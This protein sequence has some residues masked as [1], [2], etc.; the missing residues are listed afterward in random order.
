MKITDLSIDHRTTVFALVVILVILGAYTYRSLPREAFPEVEIPVVMV[1]TNFAGVS[2]KDMEGNV[3][4]PLEN[5]LKGLDD[6]EEMKS[7]SAEGV[8]TISIEFTPDVD[9][10][11]ALQKVR[12][13]VDEALPEMPEDIDDP[14][15]Q[16]ISVSDF[17]VVYV[18]V[19]GELPL[20][21][22]KAVA[23]DLEDRIEVIAGVLDADVIGG[24][25]REIR[26]ELDFD[27][28]S[29]YDIPVAD[30]LSV[31]RRENENITGGSIEMDDAKFSVRVPGEF[32]SP[33]Q[34]RNIVLTMRDGKPIYVTDVARVVDTYKDQTSRSRLN[35]RECVSIAV[36]KRSGENII[37]V[38]EAVKE[39]LDEA[40]PTLPKGVILSVSNDISK[41]VCILV[42]DL[43]NNI[44]SGFI[45]VVGVVLLFMGFRNSLFVALAVPMSM[46]ITMIVLTMLGMT[47][48]MM[49]LFSLI[50]TLGMLVD[51]AIVIVENTFRHRQ[52]GLAAADAAKTATDEVAWPVITSTLTTVCAFF[53]MIFWPGVMGQ[54]MSYLPMTVILALT[55]SLGVA[56]VIN[57]TFCARFMKVRAAQKE[58]P[59]QAVRRGYE[60]LLHAALDHRAFVC[61]LAVAGLVGTFMAYA[62]LGKGVV[63]FP[64]IDP[65][66]AYVD[67]EAPEGT[68]LDATDAI[69]R[70]VE[71][72]AADI[73]PLG[74]VKETI[75]NIGKTGGSPLRGATADAANIARIN[76]DFIDR[77]FRRES[78]WNVVKRLRKAVE[79]IA[80]AEIRVDRPEEGPPTGAPVSVEISGEDFDVLKQTAEKVKQLIKD[81]PGLVDLK[82]DFVEERPELAFRVD[83]QRAALLG[84]STVHVATVLKLAISGMKVG[85]YRELNEDYDITLRL[86]E[87]ERRTLDDIMRLTIPDLQGRQV[88]LS[89]VARMEYAPGLGAINRKD[90][91][92]VITV[93]AEKAVGY[94]SAQLLAKV[95]EKLKELAGGSS[96]YR[97][98]YTG[99]N[100]ESEKAS[101]FLGK[102]FAVAVFLILLVL[103]TQF[104]SV[105][106]P[107]IILISVI[108][109]LMGVL[110]GLIVTRTP[111]SII[112][113]GIGVVSL[114]GVVVNNAIVLIDYTEKL[115]RRG[116]D[117]FAAA[118]RAGSVRLRPV[119]LTAITTILGLLPMAVGVSYDF[120]KLQWL[121]NSESSQWWRPMAIAV[122]FG[123][124]LATV[125]TLVVVP[126]LYTLLAGDEK[127]PPE[128]S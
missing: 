22:L 128:E 75:T 32:V 104:N 34:I 89:S 84:L 6:V 121:T 52:E 116:L 60:K 25:E 112:M 83:R 102:A 5:K 41:T 63:L 15:I 12:D 16:E 3:T 42:S 92:R 23:D 70:I 127:A 65:N 18:N 105:K 21:K 39:L 68:N 97:I 66:S 28:L 58:G 45:L 40:R 122:I 108:L 1:T 67:I 80:G 118:V 59:F 103:I 51:N 49:V 30:L 82:D 111:F 124:G 9:I 2:P 99:E 79:G 100:E 27:R 88:P 126:V 95:K 119:L 77:E 125:L 87:S 94:Q 8:S 78:S 85:T 57:P 53:P 96:G 24:L 13:K 38:V 47:L 20:S 107:I 11:D 61:F 74:I 91:K 33:A 43:E 117:K 37:R 69:S 50:L 44:L 71:A 29:A 123:L 54:F 35:G 109:S 62:L 17:P 93:S 36:K 48:N 14:V 26:V 86:P 31:I 46:C 7:V 64:D 115:R 113:T 98:D 106:L 90:C 55:A 76:Y 114:A 72:K 81:I 56:M 73:D 110:W 19:S 10:E 4:I 120:K 101:A